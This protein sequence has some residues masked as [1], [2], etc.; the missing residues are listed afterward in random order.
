MP[1]RT[2][3][4]FLVT[5]SKSVFEAPPIWTKLR[6]EEKEVMGAI[7]KT[8]LQSSPWDPNRDGNSEGCRSEDTV[9]FW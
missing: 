8:H 7:L 4:A 1:L 3:R 6:R 5:V 2:L 9:S